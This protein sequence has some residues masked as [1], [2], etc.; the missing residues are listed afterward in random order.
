MDFKATNSQNTEKKGFLLKLIEKALKSWIRLKCDSASYINLELYGSNLQLLKGLIKEIHLK[1]SDVVFNDL[2]FQM[3]RINTGLIKF[4]IDPVI[5]S[6]KIK[7][8]FKIEGEVHLPS[9]QLESSLK[10]PQW[11]HLG[12]WLSLNLLNMERLKTFEI[13]NEKIKLEGFNQITKEL[14]SEF[15]SIRS[16]NGKIILYNIEKNINITLPMDD[17]IEIKKIK[18][19]KQNIIING[20]SIVNFA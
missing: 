19:T 2:S 11:E 8:N 18:I 7:E 13:K 4:K 5:K 14:R 15:F 3:V 16:Y 9:K 12:N 17:Q 6:L 1:A 10:K 20:I